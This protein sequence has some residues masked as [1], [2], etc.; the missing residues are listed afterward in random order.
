M[1]IKEISKAIYVHQNTI[2]EMERIKDRLELSPPENVKVKVETQRWFGFGDD[3]FLKKEKNEI[4]ISKYT[5]HLIL[6]TAIKNEYENISKLI[7]V[8]RNQK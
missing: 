8:T 4:P 5:M 6:D 1:N 7:E 2:N 3:S